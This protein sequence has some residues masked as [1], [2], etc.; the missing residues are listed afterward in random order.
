MATIGSHQKVWWECEK[1]HEWYA[2]IKSRCSGKKCPICANQ[3]I[4]PGIND[5]ATS[6]SQLVQEWDYSRNGDLLPNAVSA[7]SNR[8]VWWKCALGHEWAA[9]IYTRTTLGVGCPYCKNRKVLAG[10]NDLATRNPRLAAEW[11]P[12]KNGSLL[13]TQVV[14]GSNKKAW[15]K[16]SKCGWEWETVINSRNMGCGCPACAG[17]KAIYKEI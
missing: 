17:K 14:A 8:K 11:H 10:F 4:V 2:E 13:P 7:G 15:W 16:C 9:T 1:G 6:N 3:K 5:F 12:S